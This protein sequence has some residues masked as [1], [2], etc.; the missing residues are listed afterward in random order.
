MWI[1]TQ[2]FI[3]K[4]WSIIVSAFTIEWEDD[5]EIKEWEGWH[6]S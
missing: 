1:Y 3:K 4:V 6:E 5:E 2:N